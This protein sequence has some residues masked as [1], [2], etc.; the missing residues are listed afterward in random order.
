MF[1]PAQKCENYALN[2]LSA[3][4]MVYYCFFSLG[5]NLALYQLLVE[6]T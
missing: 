3:F 4:K 1:E 5:G 2:L 6:T